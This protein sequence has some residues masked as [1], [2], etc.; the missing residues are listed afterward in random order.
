MDLKRVLSTD[1]SRIRAIFLLKF[2]SL[3]IFAIV[4]YLL[5]APFISDVS[6]PAA[7]SAEIIFALVASIGLWFS[8]VGFEKEAFLWSSSCSFSKFNRPWCFLLHD[9]WKFFVNWNPVSNFG[10]NY[11][12]FSRTWLFR[13]ITNQLFVD[14]P[15]VIQSY[16]LLDQNLS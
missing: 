3:I 14:P 11:F 9:L 5:I 13:I 15:K 7:L 1:N 10:D 4:I 2:E 8:A 6:A 16:L 12:D